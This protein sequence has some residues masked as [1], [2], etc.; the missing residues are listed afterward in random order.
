MK[1]E[2]FHHDCILLAFT[3]LPPLL[4]R[5]PEILARVGERGRNFF[6]IPPGPSSC[7]VIAP[8]CASVRIAKVSMA[9]DREER[10]ELG[11]IF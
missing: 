7:L 2:F 1:S 4:N 10:G 3:L 8:A 11:F 5:D 6:L 9:F